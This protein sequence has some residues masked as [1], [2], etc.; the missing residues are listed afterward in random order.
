MDEVSA[1]STIL[2]VIAIWFLVSIVA[3]L[4][5]GAFLSLSSR[6]ECMEALAEQHEARQPHNN[7]RTSA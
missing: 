4:A 2:T 5:I 6:E 3:S 1:M 7:R